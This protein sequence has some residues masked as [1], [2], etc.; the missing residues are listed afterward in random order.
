MLLAV[1]HGVFSAIESFTGETSLPGAFTDL[2]CCTVLPPFVDCHVH[3]G[4]SGSTDPHFRSS[5]LASTY[6]KISSRISEHLHFHFTH[7]VLSVRDGGDSEGHTLR[8]CKEQAETG[9]D[10]VAVKTSGKAWHQKG[11]YGKI[12]GRHPQ[13]GVTFLESYLQENDSIDNVKIIN[14][15]INSLV[16][17]GKESGPQFAL[18]ELKNIVDEAHQRGQKVMVHANGRIPV[19]NALEAGCD[20]VEHGFFMGKANLRRL[21]ESETFWVP[22]VVAMK[23]LGERGGLNGPVVDRNVVEKTLEHQLKQLKLAREYGVKVAIGTDSGSWGVI[24]GESM[25]EELRLFMKAGYSLAEALECA[26][27]NGAQLL[28]ISDIMGHLAVG[29]P[30]NFIVARATPAMLRRKLAYL[31]GIYLGGVPCSNKY[32]KK[33]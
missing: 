4:M 22:T 15:D 2:S 20:S 1:K 32:F 27:A 14:S 21:A 30:A 19:Q 10:P 7:G 25:V 3:L 23:V 29:K 13:G 11:R 8:F 24:H 18:D 17:F 12:L 33:L 26:T 9:H 31:E 6:S 28:G 5:Q 16:E